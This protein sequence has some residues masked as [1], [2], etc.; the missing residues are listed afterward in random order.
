MFGNK[1]DPIKDQ[2]DLALS[3]HTFST[4]KWSKLN[5]NEKTIVYAAIIMAIYLILDNFHSKFLHKHKKAVYEEDPER[6]TPNYYSVLKSSE[7]I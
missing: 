6:T 5:D 2:T 4:I 1:I 3:H 7:C